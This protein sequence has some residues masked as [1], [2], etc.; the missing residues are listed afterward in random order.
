VVAS[1]AL[2]ACADDTDAEPVG[3]GTVPGSTPPTSS[4][5]TTAVPTTDAPTTTLDEAAQL[6]AEVEADFLEAFRLTDLAIQD[7]TSE[8]K[9]SAALDAYASAN[10]EFVADRIDRLRSSGQLAR[11][12]PDVSP[13]V[14][15]EVP[16]QLVHQSTET[17][18]LQACYVDP[19]L[20]VEPGAGPNGGDAVVNDEVRSYRSKFVLQLIDQRWRISGGESLGD[21]EGVG[22]PPE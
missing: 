4:P 3:T 12:N 15:V 22:C 9:V 2:A 20:I 13:A 21:W 6:A 11:A 5:P 17:A 7:P 14:D 8:E 10:R 16:A 1:V 19:W 18:F